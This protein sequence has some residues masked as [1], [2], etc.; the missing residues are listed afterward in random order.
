MRANIFSNLDSIKLYE[1]PKHHTQKETKS[2]KRK[3]IYFFRS[4]K[5]NLVF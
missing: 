2:K 3:E 5:I 1:K 4:R